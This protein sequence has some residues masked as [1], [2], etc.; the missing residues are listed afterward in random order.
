MKR[1][2]ALAPLP[3]RRSRF[4]MVAGLTLL[5]QRPAWREQLSSFGAVGRT[6][7]SNYLLQSL[8]FTLL[9][10]GCGLESTARQD[11]C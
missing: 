10:Y 2:A 7:L 4:A 3:V 9:F 1:C 8:V 6:A 11:R 5:V